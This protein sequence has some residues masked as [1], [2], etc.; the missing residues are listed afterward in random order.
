MLHSFQVSKTCSFPK[1]LVSVKSCLMPSPLM[2]TSPWKGWP[3]QKPLYTP[4][5]GT[6]QHIPASSQYSFHLLIH[7]TSDLPLTPSPSLHHT[8]VHSLPSLFILFTRPYHIS[9][10][11]FIYSAALHPLPPLFHPYQTFQ[12]CPLHDGLHL[13]LTCHRHPLYASFLQCLFMIVVLPS[14]A[15]SLVHT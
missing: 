5:S 1:Y 15:M 6:P 4:C 12:V 13:K 11:S 3:Q 14:M 9:V 10:H 8:L 2:E 7:F